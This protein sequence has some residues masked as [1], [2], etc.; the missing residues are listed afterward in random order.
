MKFPKLISTKELYHSRRNKSLVCTAICGHFR[1]DYTLLRLNPRSPT[2]SILLRLQADL[3]KLQNLCPLGS[4]AI[5]DRITWPVSTPTRNHSGQD[6]LAVS[7][8]ICD[9]LRVQPHDS[10]NNGIHIRL[11]RDESQNVQRIELYQLEEANAGLPDRERSHR[12]HRKRY[13]PYCDQN[14]GLEPVG[15]DSPRHNLDVSTRNRLLHDGVIYIIT[16]ITKNASQ[17]I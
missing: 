15:P 4:G 17:Y 10:R 14:R 5:S 7:T 13:Y 3:I 16:H 6:K 2:N 1:Y 11:V 9:S 12:P 8:P